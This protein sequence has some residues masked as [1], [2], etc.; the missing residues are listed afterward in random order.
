MAR[1]NANLIRRRANPRN[2]SSGSELIIEH[3]V[4]TRNNGCRTTLAI[5]T[6]QLSPTNCYDSFHSNQN[7]SRSHSSS[8]RPNQISNSPSQITLCRGDMLR[9][10]T[11]ANLPVSP[12]RHSTMSGASYSSCRLCANATNNVTEYP[13]VHSSYR[14]SGGSALLV[15]PEHPW[16]NCTPVTAAQILGSRQPRKSTFS[17]VS[18]P[19]REFNER[20]WIKEVNKV[21]NCLF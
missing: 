1:R 21:E 15:S 13:R 11:I 12:S 16:S 9:A 2:T 6:S 8:Q 10:G 18:I 3:P 4:N 7:N 20:W 14:N 19:L 5:K 17:R